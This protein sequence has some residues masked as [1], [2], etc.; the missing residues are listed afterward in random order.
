M[1]YANTTINVKIISTPKRSQAAK[2][3]VWAMAA[4]KFPW[5]P[6]TVTLQ[7]KNAKKKERIRK[8]L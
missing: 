7:N 3:D 1:K 5:Y 8:Q 6:G 4:C 2:F